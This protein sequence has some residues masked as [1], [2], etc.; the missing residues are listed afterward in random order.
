MRIDSKWGTKGKTSRNDYSMHQKAAFAFCPKVVGLGSSQSRFFTHGASS[1]ILQNRTVWSKPSRRRAFASTVSAR[2]ALPWQPEFEAA[3][4]NREV[5]QELPLLVPTTPAPTKP[6]RGLTVKRIKR[7]L[8]TTWRLAA[9]FWRSDRTARWHALSCALLHVCNSA[10]G[11]VFTELSG[12]LITA[13]N[14]RNVSGFSTLTLQLFGL[15]MLAVPISAF[16]SFVRSTLILRWQQFLTKRGLGL[17]FEESNYYKLAN[18]TPAKQ[19]D[20]LSAEE[21]EPDNPDEVIDLRFSDFASNMVDIAMDNLRTVVEI[22]IYSVM[23]LRIFPPLYLCILGIV[24]IGMVLINRIGRQLVDLEALLQRRA[25]VSF[26]LPQKRSIE[27][28]FADLLT[29]FVFEIGL[30]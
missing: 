26:I 9:P 28:S 29:A 5:G 24:G 30:T 22:C 20:S 25:A 16:T 6:T 17:Y 21:E 11:A 23:L 10:F 15:C 27:L 18:L 7:L 4:L 13:L 8:S 14:E 3:V 19:N 2:A 1:R 12:N